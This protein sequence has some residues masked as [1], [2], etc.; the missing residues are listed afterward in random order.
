[1]TPSWDADLVAGM[2]R[3]GWSA[4]VIGATFHISRNAVIGRMHR[5]PQLHGLWARFATGRQKRRPRKL[6]D[7]PREIAKNPPPKALVRANWG[8][9]EE[10]EMKP[11]PVRPKSMVRLKTGE[12]KWPVKDAPNIT[13]GFLFCAHPVEQGSSYCARHTAKA[14][15]GGSA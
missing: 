11:R 3:A 15:P 6:P 5:D 2:V 10:K 4:S 9:W 13:G 14:R 12:C 7:P 1:M 8:A